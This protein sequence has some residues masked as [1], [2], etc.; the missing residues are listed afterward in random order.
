MTRFLTT[1]NTRKHL[2][3]VAALMTIVALLAACAMPAMPGTAPAAE[4]PAA[5][6]EP[7]A[8]EAP[9]SSGAASALDPNE[10]DG[11]YTSAPDMTIDPS[12]FYYAT[13]ATE[14]GDIKVQLYAD[15]APMTVNNFVFLARE[16]FYD[17]TTF[18]RVL[19][20][21]MAQAGDPTG[22]GMG[23][24]GYNFADEF[25]PGATFDRRGL[26]A[27]A[28]AGP[29]TN[30]SQFF[31]TFA[32]TPW[33][34]GGHTIFGEVIEGD[35][36]LSQITL[37]D[38]QGGATEP[39]DL[40]KSITIEESD[41][42]TLPTP[43]ALPPTPTPFPPTSLVGERPLAEL[44]GAEKANYFNAPPEMVI[45]TAKSYTATISTSQGDM[46]ATLYDDD[47]PVAVNN[48]VV[49][50]NLGFFDNT[51]VNDVN[52][53]QLVV[54]GAPDNDPGRDVGYTF[55]PEVGLPETPD[56]GSIT[57]RSLQQDPAG[58]VIASGSQLF[59]ALVAPPPDVVDAYSFFGK[60]V[61]GVE[62]LSTLTVSDTIESITIIE[63]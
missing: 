40:I 21:F 23:G 13:I 32:P 41:S 9:A 35:D 55:N 27:M 22:T 52:P 11:M 37:R 33:L 20:D 42:S 2:W 12:K 56:V 57:Y 3:Q 4:A 58:G 26:L 38:P 44:S 46:V 36:V 17:N 61:D 24:P 51:P 16:G 14:L 39:G 28:N 30:G 63:E 60:I 54:I 5:A 34:D 62:V 50:A 47:A 31:I 8:A 1:K 10:R 48:F 29:G 7:V 18:H 6:T 59:L 49:L 15:R 43:T 53:E 25:W 19:Q 45:D